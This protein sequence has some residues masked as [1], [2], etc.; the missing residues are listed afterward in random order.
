[1]NFGRPPLISRNASTSFTNK[2][3]AA[4]SSS[5]DAAPQPQA[6]WQRFI[7]VAA[8]ALFVI[9]LLWED[10]V[11]INSV[12]EL[13]AL[14]DKTY[15][16]AHDDDDKK[17]TKSSGKGG[18]WFED[19]NNAKTVDPKKKKN[20]DANKAKM[21][22]PIQKEVDK[23]IHNLEQ[24][25]EEI[26][27]TTLVQKEDDQEKNTDDNNQPTSKG[28]GSSS[29][30]SAKDWTNAKLFLNHWLDQRQSVWMKQ[31]QAD[32]G[33]DYALKLFEPLVEDVVTKH[34]TEVHNF[35][36]PRVSL[37]REQVFKDPSQLRNKRSR[38]IGNY[39]AHGAAWYRLARKQSI[40]ALQ[41]Q[42]GLLQKQ[43]QP[44]DNNDKKYYSSFTWVTGGH[45]SAAGHGNFYP[46]SY[47]G[48]L[49]ADLR[50][51]FATIGLDFNAKGY[52][53]GGTSSGEEIGLCFNSVYGKED[54]DAISWDFGMTD[55]RLLL[56]CMI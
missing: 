26:P 1:M 34:D 49:H 40:K 56:L 10:E 17:E 27:D 33:P 51:L 53:M 44:S 42:L 21:D 23:P 24:D 15:V 4:S 31:L 55:G 13:P 43:L 54:V 28:D 18:G 6:K 7:V 19:D 8:L 22:K 38:I 41:L 3:S 11:E 5:P 32:Y 25:N 9:F 37:G 48:I 39:T 16:I 46:E 47:T 50:P 20:D 14:T 52:A 29:F 12:G 30:S 45:S 36:S 2:T 35:T